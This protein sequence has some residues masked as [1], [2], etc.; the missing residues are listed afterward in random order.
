MSRLGW[1]VS[2]TAAVAIA[3]GCSSTTPTAPSAA[4]AALASAPGALDAKVGGN[5]AVDIG[6]RTN[7]LNAVHELEGWLNDAIAAPGSDVNCGIVR[8]LDAKLEAIASALDQTP[9]HFRP[10]CG[11]SGALA[12]ELEALTG[13]GALELPSFLPPFPGG[14]T[15]VLA[16]AQGLNERWCAAARGEIV[17]PRS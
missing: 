14:P 3:V 13:R 15:N 2:V 7:P 17:G 5:C 1:I 11:V 4:G 6:A 8:S 16:A 12:N 10:A 9:P